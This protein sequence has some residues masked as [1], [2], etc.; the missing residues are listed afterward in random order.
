MLWY[1][2]PE[3]DSGQAISEPAQ[4]VY[5][6]NHLSEKSRTH[7]HPANATSACWLRLTCYAIGEPT[8]QRDNS[9]PILS[10][11]EAF[12]EVAVFI[13]PMDQPVRADSGIRTRIWRQNQSHNQQHI[14][15]S[16]WPRH[17]GAI[18]IPA[19]GLV[20]NVSIAMASR[21]RTITT[22]VDSY[23]AVF[24]RSSYFFSYFSKNF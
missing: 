19:S 4:C 12:L 6:M 23:C 5:P 17:Y 16:Q 18:Q 11:W 14:E 7:T 13:H 20:I 24:L 9:E 1:T 21:Q 15:I 2:R 10:S 22:K 8:T 3:I